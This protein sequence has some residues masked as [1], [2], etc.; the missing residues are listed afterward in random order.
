MSRLVSSSLLALSFTSWLAS[1]CGGN[2]ARSAGGM[3]LAS[4]LMEAPTGERYA[5]ISEQGLVAVTDA[6]RST[7]AID[8]DTAAMANVRRFLDD[9][10]LPPANAVRVEEM[11]NYFG[12]ADPP[13]PTGTPIAVHTEIAP[14]PLHADRQLAR[15]ALST[16]ELD[17]A[18]APARNLVFL[19]DTSGSMMSEDKLP[20]LVYGLRV[21]IESLRPQ[22]RVAIVTYAGSASVALPPTTGDRRAII[23]DALASLTAGGSTAGAE[24]IATAYALAEEHWQRGGINRVILATDGDFNVGMADTASL[25]SYIDGKRQTGVGLTVLGFGTGNLGDELMEQLADHGDG[26]YGYIDGP[27]E[28]RKL[29]AEEAG[30]TLITIAKDVKVQV[31]FDPAQVAS[32]RLIGYENRA[33]A[34]ADFRNDEKDGGELGAGHHVTALYEYVPAPD[35]RDGAASPFVVRVRYQDPRS[36]IDG[37]LLTKAG[38]P[39]ASIDAASADLRFAAAVAGFGLVLRGSEHRGSATYASVAGLAEGAVGDDPRRAELLAL[40]GKAAALAGQAP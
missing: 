36:G 34:D 20:L 26:N 12:Y 22:D 7:F 10:A 24:G 9:G 33:L 16:A 19:V 37:E 13:P 15:V 28:A 6:P 30:S 3:V 29:L 11:I 25:V 38:A 5:A 31:E 32:Y 18:A 1:A 14:S 17:P 23:E 27:Q 2:A 21:L 8:V 39:V 4:P 40:I 35:A